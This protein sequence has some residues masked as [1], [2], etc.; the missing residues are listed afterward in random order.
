[1]AD[2]PLGPG[3]E[4]VAGLLVAEYSSALNVDYSVAHSGLFPGGK[5]LEVCVVEPSPCRYRSTGKYSHDA[6]FFRACERIFE[7]WTTV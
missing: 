3:P 1:V 5:M 4:A 2:V 7:N 6:K